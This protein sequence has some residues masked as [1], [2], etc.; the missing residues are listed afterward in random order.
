MQ[1]QEMGPALGTERGDMCY[2]GEVLCVRADK[3]G[4]G[5]AKI[6]GWLVRI[7]PRYK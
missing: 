1:H 7:Y 6:I 4:L 3:R 2:H 5:I